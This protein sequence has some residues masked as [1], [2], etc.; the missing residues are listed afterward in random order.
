ME[1]K[2]ETKKKRGKGALGLGGGGH[3]ALLYKINQTSNKKRLT[4]VKRIKNYT[5]IV[6]DIHT[7]NRVHHFF[8]N[9]Q[10]IK[11]FFYVV[12]QL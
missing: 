1:R 9:I 7:E 8:W 10:K 6:T 3:G 5:D 12:L 11:Y 2:R 4:P